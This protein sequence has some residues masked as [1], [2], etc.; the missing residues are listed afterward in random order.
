M[1][2]E[3]KEWNFSLCVIENLQPYIIQLKSLKVSRFWSRLKSHLTR[4]EGHSQ[5]HK[6]TK[7]NSRANSWE[8]DYHQWSHLDS[9]PCA[10]NGAKSTSNHETH[11]EPS[12]K[13]VAGCF[14][15]AKKSLHLSL[16]TS[17]LNFFVFRSHVSLK[18]L[19]CLD[20]IIHFLNFR[21]FSF[22]GLIWPNSIS[23]H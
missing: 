19:H 22:D 12:H 23:R 2:K 21:V 13:K 5:S 11:L 6:E 8:R 18:R 1:P 4:A 9:L 17:Q 16:H 3:F 14:A 7:R 20:A 15:W 10:Q